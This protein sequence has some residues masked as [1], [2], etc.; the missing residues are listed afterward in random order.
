M[1]DKDLVGDSIEDLI[2]NHIILDINTVLIDVEIL[3]KK[4]SIE[5]L[6]YYHKVL[7]LRKRINIS[8]SR[9]KL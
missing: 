7:L 5:L 8:E 9:P 1:V 6:F 2:V 4:N 3:A